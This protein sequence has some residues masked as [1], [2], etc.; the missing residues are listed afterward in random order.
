MTLKNI[1]RKTTITKDL[2]VAKSFKNR[3]LGLLDSKSP[4][5]L[6]INTRFGIHT[7]FLK[8]KIDVIIT[9]DKFQIKSLKSLGTNR[10]YVYN[11][12]NSIVIELPIGSIKK[13]KTKIGDTLKMLE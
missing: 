1:T 7:F 10:L 9:D 12:K 4:R 8:E 5:S 11:P 2:K 6:L 13:S 3:A